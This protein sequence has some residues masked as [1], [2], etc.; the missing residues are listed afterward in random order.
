[1]STPCFSPIVPSLQTD[2]LKAF[3]AGDYEEAHAYYTRSLR[4]SPSLLAFNNRAMSG[5]SQS[6]SALFEA[7]YREGSVY[8]VFLSHQTREIFRG[9]FGLFES[10][11]GRP[12]QHKR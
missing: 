11:T 10:S 7:T 12:Y 1:M 6:M 5:L 8:N 3:K 4:V 9:N 2:Y